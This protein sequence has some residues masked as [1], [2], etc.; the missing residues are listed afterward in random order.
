MRVCFLVCPPAGH[1]LE[2][3]VPLFQLSESWNFHYKHVSSFGAQQQQLAGRVSEH[4]RHSGHARGGS[5]FGMRRKVASLGSPLIEGICG[6]MRANPL[7]LFY[8]N[9]AS[10]VKVLV[11]KCALP[12][13]SRQSEASDLQKLRKALVTS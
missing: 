4:R 13:W 9:S 7:S 1:L 6:H 10:S 11:E 8:I 3:D 2:A 12:R 5:A